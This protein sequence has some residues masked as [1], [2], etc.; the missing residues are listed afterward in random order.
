MMET[1]GVIDKYTMSKNRLNNFK[2]MDVCGGKL[3]K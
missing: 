2:L 1:M 3:R